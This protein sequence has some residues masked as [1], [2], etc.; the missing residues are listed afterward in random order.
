MQPD[1]TPQPGMQPD[2]PQPGIQPGIPTSET[3]PPGLVQ[4][5]TLTPETQIGSPLGPAPDLGTPIPET[6]SGLSAPAAEIP[7][8][9]AT[10]PSSEGQMA[11]DQQKHDQE[12]PEDPAVQS[13]KRMAEILGAQFS[14]KPKEYYEA[15]SAVYDLASKAAQGKANS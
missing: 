14:G 8:P 9:T 3:Q 13:A 7:T 2:M 11:E 1:L 10:P 5:P 4:T 15:L 12:R 6:Q